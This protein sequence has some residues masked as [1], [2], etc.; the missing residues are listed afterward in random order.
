MSTH[1]VA[2]SE[3]VGKKRQRGPAIIVIAGEIV[4]LYIFRKDFRA[5]LIVELITLFSP[6]S[7]CCA[8]S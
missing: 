1:S 2:Y 5:N 3:Q 4:T 8:V 7:A 6:G